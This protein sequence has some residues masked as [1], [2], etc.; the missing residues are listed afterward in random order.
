MLHATYPICLG[1]KGGAL[2]NSFITGNETW[3]Y[4]LSLETKGQNMA[5]KTASENKPKNKAKFNHTTHCQE[6]EGCGFLGC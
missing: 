5:W 1:N 4:Y 3:V 6:S 2:V